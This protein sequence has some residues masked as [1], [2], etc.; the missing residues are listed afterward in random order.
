[1]KETD[2][3]YRNRNTQTKTTSENK[4]GS[5]MT[6]EDWFN[7]GKSDAWVG[8]P[9][10]PPQEN[11]QAASMYELGYC[12]GEIKRAPIETRAADQ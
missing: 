2:M 9:K 11:S 7:L 8:Q 12:E 6:D 1:M 4:S 3:P 5:G 10:V